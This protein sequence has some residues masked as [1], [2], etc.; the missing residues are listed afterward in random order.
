MYRGRPIFYGLSSLISGFGIGNPNYSAPVEQD[1]SLL[2]RV[3][4]T[5][6]K[7]TEVALYPLVRMQLTKATQ[8]EDAMPK[9]AQRILGNLQRL[10][11]PP[12]T[13]IIIK[14][15]VGSV[16]LKEGKPRSRRRPV[17]L[18]ANPGRV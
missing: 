14:G 15:D 9:L 16:D 12:G 13:T 4:Y 3:T 10:S 2:A 11:Q 18:W 8:R 7:V 17:T 6:G 1:D 5:D